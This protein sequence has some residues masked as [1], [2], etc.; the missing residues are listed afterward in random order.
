[1]EIESRRQRERKK[2]ERSIRSEKTHA[3][4]D[5]APSRAADVRKKKPAW[6][7]HALKEGTPGN[8]K[9]EGATTIRDCPSERRARPAGS[10]REENRAEIPTQAQ[11]SN[12]RK[13]GSSPGLKG[14]RN[15][16][17]SAGKESDQG[18]VEVV[19]PS[20]EPRSSSNSKDPPR[21]SGKIAVYPPTV[22]PKRALIKN[23]Q[24]KKDLQAGKKT[25]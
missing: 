24:L 15:P 4:S 14:K 2:L 20:G 17:E 11:L 6:E 13:K 22:R 23:T 1:V 3:S 12:A 8:I 19:T 18:K 7:S 21:L 5:L 9:G 25:L 10:R 16:F